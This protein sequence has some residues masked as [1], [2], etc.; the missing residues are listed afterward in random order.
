MK[1]PFIIDVRPVKSET[2][3]AKDYLKLLAENPTLVSRAEFVPPKPGKDGFGAF[4]VHYSRAR[5]RSLVH[6]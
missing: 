1:K 3:S 6:G 4:L 5:H 2:I